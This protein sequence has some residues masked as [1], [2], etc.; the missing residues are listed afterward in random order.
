MTAM[1]QIL[2]V[3][4]SVLS[5]EVSAPNQGNDTRRMARILKNRIKGQG[6]RIV[7]RDIA[8]RPPMMV[9]QNF[10]HAANTAAPLRT[11]AQS[12]RLKESDELVDEVLKSDVIVLS[13]PIYRNGVPAPLRAWVRNIVRP[14]MTFNTVEGKKRTMHYGLLHNKMF[15]LLQSA[16][17]ESANGDVF[18]AASNG[19]DA[20]EF[21]VTDTLSRL[22]VHNIARVSVRTDPADKMHYARSWAQCEGDIAS[23]AE[24]LKT[25]WR[26]QRCDA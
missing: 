5:G 20:P 8:A 17:E 10:V 4:S 22:G 23:V 12:E 1:P 21:A 6:V 11:Y 16:Y 15:V 18:K 2:F 24:R 13:C 9:D 3:H 7:D 19:Q 26:D 25:R 14:G